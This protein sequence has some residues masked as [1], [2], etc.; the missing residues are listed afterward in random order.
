V[1]THITPEIRTALGV[2]R[3]ALEGRDSA[4]GPADAIVGGLDSAGLLMSPE[5]AAELTR[6]RRE[7][8][9]LVESM[10]WHPQVCPAAQH[11]PWFADTA[12]P[13]P[14]PWCQI[15][16]LQTADRP[17]YVYRAEHDGIPF[18][19]Y[20][21]RTA[22]RGHVEVLLSAESAGTFR[23]EPDDE[24]DPESAEE[25]VSVPY[26]GTDVPTGYTVTAV[27]VDVAYD[28]EAEG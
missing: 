21:S 16:E 14:C 7:H 5:T 26:D 9:A 4:Y 6:L 24:T 28:P 23:W 12:K 22:A 3:A 2:A 8:A 15:A 27:P 10:T 17:A 13:L 18:G 20:W 25:A 11:R 19:T 1:T